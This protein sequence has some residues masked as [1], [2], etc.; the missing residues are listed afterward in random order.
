MRDYL[1]SL[2]KASLYRQVIQVFYPLLLKEEVFQIDLW[3]EP[4]ANEEI[5][6]EDFK[7]NYVFVFL[8]MLY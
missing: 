5:T 6:L 8:L 3:L 7:R 2:F 4:G 1:R